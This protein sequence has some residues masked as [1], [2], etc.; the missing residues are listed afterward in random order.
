MFSNKYKPF[1]KIDLK[2][3][4]WP[5][6]E[7]SQAPNWCSVDLR[8]GNQALIKPMDMAKKLEFFDLLVKIGFKTIE[9][10]FPSASKVEFDFTRRL[11]EENRIPDDVTIQVLVQAREHLIEKTR[12]ALRGAKNV[13]VHMYNSTSTM[14]REMVFQKSQDE[15]I[16]IAKDGAKLVR[17]YF[18]DFEGNLNLEYSPES[19]TQTE[20]DFA[21]KICQAVGKEW[22]GLSKNKI[23][24]NLPATVEVA[25]PNIYADQIEW[26]INNI[27]NREDYLISLHAHNDRGTAVAATELALMAGA[28]RVEGTLLGNGERTG[29]VD[30]M[31]VALNMFTQGIDPQLDFSQINEVA[32]IVEKCTEIDTHIRHPYVGKMVY[33]AFSGSHQDAINKGMAHR[34][35]KENSLWEVPYL[36]IDPSDVGRAYEDL[37]RINS[38]SGKGGVAFILEQKFNY[39]IPKKMH[40]IVGEVIQNIA[41]IKGDVLNNDEILEA[42]EKHFLVKPE[43]FQPMKVTSNTDAITKETTVEAEISYRGQT[44]KESKKGGG[45]IEAM[46]S[47]ISNIIN[48]EFDVIDYHEH[49]LNIGTDAYAVAYI[50]IQ[51]EKGIVFGVGKERNI[52]LASINA[53]LNAVDQI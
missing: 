43:T 7:I 13:V 47:I 46:S 37:I 33:T 8:D 51:T 10:G 44:Y 4:T 42:F 34:A 2:K 45:P 17:S 49:S 16:T 15:I 53:L 48:T 25:T 11:I 23:I 31:T 22:K 32:R 18:E 36:P 41:D 35:V 12:D 14:Q 26:F 27:E 29:N 24:L 6:N 3:R 40:P 5:D 38:Q 1:K 39:E 21:V 50:G 19:F 20:L 30:I 52:T 9:I 28:D